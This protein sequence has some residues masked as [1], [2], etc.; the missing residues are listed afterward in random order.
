M[1]Q[2]YGEETREMK[3][4][5]IKREKG[6]NGGQ[7]KM[8]KRTWILAAL[9]LA[10]TLT[11]CGNAAQ[12]D[13]GE[14]VP[15]DGTVANTETAVQDGGDAEAADTDGA[16]ATDASEEQKEVKTPTS[17]NIITVSDENPDVR[18]AMVADMAGVKD[19]SYNQGAWQGLQNLVNDTNARSSYVKANDASQYELCFDLL[20]EDG[21]EM[22]WG[23]GYNFSEVVPKMAE[24]YPDVHFGIVDQSYDEIPPNLTCVTF[25]MDEASFL[26]GYIA[27]N[28]TET[29]KVGFV[30][31]TDS[32]V[33]NEFRDGYMQGVEHAAKENGKKVEVS[34]NYVGDFSDEAKGKE[35]ANEMYTAG[36]DIVYH[37]AGG[38]GIGVF[39]AAVANDAYVIGVD[40]DQSYLAPKNVL[41]S[42]LKRVD[43]VIENLSLQYA[44]GDNIGGRSLEFG[45]KE[46][47]VGIPE[48]HD[49]YSDELYER[50]Q[51]ISKEICD[52]T[53][54]LE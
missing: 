50:V 29:G 46:H 37:A 6:I 4:A 53:I 34:V 49:N 7:R 47:A 16:E 41:T 1:G 31:G 10:L 30:G 28:V 20:V 36:C 8:K 5:D 27:A 19:H 12:T 22:C 18:V 17:E 51:E 44:I 54:V 40:S 24:K 13:S 48:A 9:M 15:K 42:A 3:L 25:R 23:L 21:N 2:R 14:D 26:V 38:A 33:I 35:V 39:N 43:I 52:G 11:A 45:L 32:D